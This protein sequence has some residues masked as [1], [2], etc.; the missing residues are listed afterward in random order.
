MLCKLTEIITKFPKTTIA[1]FL[2]IT[3]FFAAQFPKMKID[4]DPENMLEQKQA[5]RIFYDKV[6]KEFGIH[7]LLVVGIVDE[8]GIFNQDT[9]KRIAKVTDDILKIKGV[10]IEDVVSL[11]TSDNVTS[12]GG[13]LV[14]KRFMEEVPQNQ[15]EIENLKKALYGNPFFVDKIISRD[16]TAT[17]IYIPIESKNQSYRISKEVEKILKKELAPEQKYYLAGLPVAEDTFGHEMFVQ[18]GITAPLAGFFIMILLFLIFRMGIAVIPPMLDAMLSVIWTMGLL[19]G[20]GFTVHIMSSMIPIFLM[21][22][23]LLDDI[24]ILS[25]FFDRYPL[26]KDKRKTLILTMKDLYRPMFFT[27]ITSAVGF[28]SLALADIPPV[29]VFGLFV[30][31]GIMA[32]WLFTH[33]IVP[34]FI[35]L[36]NEE[37]LAAFLEKR[38]KRASILDKILKAFGRFSFHRSKAILLASPLVLVL[39]IIG[40]YQIHINDNPVKWFKPK[41][42][43][44]IADDV[45]NKSFGG[46]YMAYLA[47]EG[48]K[49][50]VIK[51]PEAMSYL[52]K[53]QSHLEGLKIVGKTSSVADI[54]KRINYVLHDENKSFNTVP[55]NQQEIGQY[56]FLFSM[57]GDPND[58]DNFL[59]Y[60]SQKANIWIQMKGGDNTQMR[61]V[62]HSAYDFMKENAPPKDITI[63]WSGL[64][65]IN[66][67]W[68]NLMV[69]GM[70]KAVLGSFVIVF[71][72]M[73]LEFRS[74]RLGIISMLPLTIAIVSSYGLV[75]F[76]GKDYDMPIAVCGALALGMAIDF[77]IHYL[78]RFKAAYRE[79]KDLEATNTFMAG[80]PYRA[81]MGN[82]IVIS[83]GFLP[84]ITSTLTP[85]VTVGTFFALLM[86]FSTLATL[87]LLPAIMRLW[88]NSLF[89][90]EVSK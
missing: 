4:T 67:V 25:G 54:V 90:K 22:I 6:K 1:L 77:A 88:G 34:A 24:H 33:T 53:L 9:L 2:I 7:D 55:D 16:G 5:D 30:A 79:F 73:V 48:D 65:Y 32:A 47:A 76:A 64:T 63:R 18:M 41:H 84:L 78:Q 23:A 15:E 45:M 31:F 28:G 58:L 42:K 59:D 43:I 20:L 83:L 60:S 61:E 86:V 38:Q 68:Q 89:Q 17:S 50:D 70:L 57:T 40:I 11:R 69:W 10:I 39:G 14:V 26:I 35:M 36:M 80:E 3:V 82:A 52:D 56:L 13:T 85:Y 37:K 87:I 74:L 21:P 29:R 72:L 66:K 75:G 8:K 81:I 51:R 62:E 44:R 49:E 71:L 19:I 12:E 46:T 27:S